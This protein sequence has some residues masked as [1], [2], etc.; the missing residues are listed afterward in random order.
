MSSE[1]ACC[2]R[3][4]L[5]GK[6]NGHLGK[7]ACIEIEWFD[8]LDSNEV[9]LEV[10]RAWIQDN[11]VLGNNHGGHYERKWILGALC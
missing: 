11:V 6:G 2:F 5:S 8:R 4:S 7:H 1:S 10:F 3:A 9:G